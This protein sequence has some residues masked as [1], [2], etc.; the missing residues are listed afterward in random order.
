MSSFSA[1]T[2]IFA[3]LWGRLSDRIGRRP[4]LIV[5]LIGSVG[6]YILFG[7]ATVFQSMAL[8]FVARIGAGIAGATIPAAQAYI[9]DVTSLQ[10]RAK[11]M[12]LIGAAFGLGFTFG[13]LLGAAALL[14][15]A[16]CERQSVAR[17]CGGRAVGYRFA[18][19]DFSACP[20]RCGPARGRRVT[21]IFDW[22]A[23]HDAFETVSVPALLATAFAS[24]VS[25]AAFETTLSLL[26]NDENLAFKFKFH[27]VLLYYA[28]IGLTLS[29]AQGFLVRRLAP[30]VGEVRN[31]AGRRRHHDA[32]LRPL[33]R[34]QP[35]GELWLLMLASAI[36][37]TGFALMTPSLQSLISRRSDPAKQGGILGV[38]QSTSSLARV[39]GPLIA[40]PLFFQSP[41]LP[42]WAAMGIM[43]V[44]TGIFVLFA[45]QGTDYATAAE[46]LSVP[47]EALE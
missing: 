14:F 6:F 9:A 25:F 17:L 42:Y 19:G 28:F 24:V 11:G 36:E 12:A 44:S 47:A 20:S 15:S 27:Q 30:I 26:L 3:P 35:G 23:W 37:V 31:D 18:A 39:V 43:A 13:P 5:G 29:I 10:N 46:A 1:M 33:D 21:R 8:L 41:P 16:R 4:V 32:R 2:F 45:R 34:G 7:V 38:S 40:V 22:R